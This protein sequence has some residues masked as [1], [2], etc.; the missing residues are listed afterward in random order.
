[1]A[2]G[3][4]LLRRAGCRWGIV[5]SLGLS[6][7]PALTSCHSGN[8][9]RDVIRKKVIVLGIDGM[10]PGI[11][12]GLVEEGRMPNF[13]RLMEE[14]HFRPLR[15]GIPPQSPVAWSNFITGMNPGGHGIFDFIHR[16]PATLSP[17]LSTS[18]TE[19]G[20]YS[21]SLGSWRIPLSA[22]RVSLLRRGRAFWEVLGRNG[23]PS[24]ILRVPANFPPAGDSAE[25]LSGM[26]TPDL[27]GTYGTFSFYTQDP[28]P[29]GSD[30]SGGKIFPLNVHHR[31][32][33][34]Q[35]PGPPNTFRTGRAPASVAFEGTVDPE[36]RVVRIEVQDHQFLLQEGS[37]SEWIEV[38]FE[39]VP[40]IH[41][42]RGICR[43]Y[44]KEVDP[45]LKIYVTPVNIHPESPALLISNPPDYSHQMC[46]RI[47]LFSTL[48]IPEDTKALSS[49]VLDD[50]EFLQQA[51][52][53][54]QEE[55]R[56]LD[57]GLGNFHQGLFFF[58]LGRLDQLSHMFWRTMDPQHPSYQENSPHAEV[59][60]D[61]YV[62]MDRVLGQV[63]EKVDDQ[64]TILVMSDH[65]FAPFYRSFH[66]NSWL[67]EQGYITLVDFSEGGMLRNVDWS[68]S[69]AYGFGFNGLYVNLYG[70]EPR[71]IV[72]AGA[73]REALL[74]EIS[75]GLLNLRDPETGVA[76]VT[77]VYRPE[78]IY[79]GPMVQQGPDLVIGYNRGY[80]ASWET[81]LGRFPEK[82]LED[83]LDKWSGDHL[84]NAG[85]VPGILI[86]NRK[87]KVED[88]ALVDLAPTILAEFGV[89][90]D[91]V[92]M[93]RLLF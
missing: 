19:E 70:R 54:F 32:F 77:R 78:R 9:D 62:E 72:R 35:L 66:L 59:I 60:P 79:S 81:T 49:G 74:E 93:G 65:G 20:S 61:G 76:V 90:K 55:L 42:V 3:P 44:L 71:G 27:Q 29:R 68:R 13:G 75:A 23:I 56:M 18:R 25:Q 63:L 30:V 31:H 85:V 28:E 14:G 57:Y 92:M 67:K 69:R 6:L 80:R 36:N 40:F 46:E 15:T 1:M 41:G 22:G 48:G 24:T 89:P 37:W 26:G 17:Y 53:V 45:H 39:L 16:D 38:E 91:P 2:V 82:I 12:A 88:P 10:D 58:Y 51:D 21:L 4:R 8:Q 52:W 34:A 11:L 5:L 33:E 43:F 84:M 47:G 86:S 87:I 64:T 73:D 7:Q 50:A 83:N